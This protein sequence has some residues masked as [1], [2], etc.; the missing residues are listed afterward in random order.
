VVARLAG[1][2][3]DLRDRQTLETALRHQANH[4]PLTGLPNR[5]LFRDQVASALRSRRQVGILFIDL[6]DFKTVNDS[7]GH[8]RGDALLVAVARRLNTLHR[9]GDVAARLG[10]DE[11]AI[12]LLDVD[13]TSAVAAAERLLAA[14][15]EP[16]DLPSGPAVAFASIGIRIS[17]PGEHDAEVILRDADI[18]MYR[19]KA[20]GK[21]RYAMFERPMH[22]DVLAQRRV[23]DSIERA[24]G[25]LL[26]YQPIVD[27]A[28][29]GVVG[30]EALARW[31][32]QDGSVLPPAV[33]IPIAENAG[34]I[35]DLGEQILHA[36]FAQ[37][38]SW[39]TAHPDLEIGVNVSAR[40]L[41]DPRF[42]D[43]VD[44]ALER[45]RLDP[46]R[47]VLELTET[48]L[49]DVHYVAPVLDALVRRGLRLALDDFGT[50]YSSLSHLRSLPISI[51]KIDRTFIARLPERGRDAALVEGVIGLA[52]TLGMRTIGE[53]IETESQLRRL[54]DVGCELGQGYLLGRPVAAES[55]PLARDAAI[56]TSPSVSVGAQPAFGGA[57]ARSV[58]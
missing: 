42:T 11:F 23:R 19:A 51:V 27:L 6:D 17:Q 20:E 18:A 53:G 16:L 32:E 3:S 10:G 57:A 52:R 33:F 29:G 58:A 12:L 13:S 41:S 55:I 21:G 15:R 40:Q 44:A 39:S 47:V 22:S 24:D 9:A 46:R 5:S 7:F 2:V 49:L 1:V 37:L 34:L 48:A 35:A 4:D 45:A 50:G 54:R 56:P 8:E 26:H 43:R 36:A 30:Y 38:T 31:R 28:T 25:L 14:L